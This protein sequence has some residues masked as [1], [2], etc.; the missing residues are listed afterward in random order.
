MLPCSCLFRFLRPALPAALLTLLLLPACDPRQ[1]PTQEP[2]APAPTAAP[3]PATP[4]LAPAAPAAPADSVA[5]KPAHAG[6]SAAERDFFTLSKG[7]LG[8]NLVRLNMSEAQLRDVV[9]AAQL[10]RIT[11]ELEGIEY[12][13]YELRH[14]RF[15]AAPP[16]LL[17]LAEDLAGRPGLRIWRMEVRDPRF[18]TGN[19]NIG[20]GSTYGEARRAYGVQFVQR[21]DAG[22][23]AVSE[24]VNMSWVL[25]GR[26]ISDPVGR[27]LSKDDIPAGTRIVGILLFR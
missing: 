10:K 18:R 27:P 15:P 11:R 5:D 9:P 16:T 7:R 8:R 26:G 25:D 23:V 17:E 4:P 12:P 1:Q 20:V 24:S 3:A 21:A 6:L 2:A 14:P 13:A 19:G 22:L